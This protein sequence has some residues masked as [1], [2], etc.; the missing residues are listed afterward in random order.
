MKKITITMLILTIISIS[1]IKVDAAKV[2]EK[3]DIKITKISNPDR[4]EREIDGLMEGGDR[5]NSYTWRL[6]ER[7]DYI[8]IATRNIASAL[9]NMYAEAFKEGGIS[10]DVLWAMVD[11]I[12]N[13]DIP[14]NDELNGAN[15]LSYN[16]KTGEFK[17][18][19][20]A[21]A[22]T[23]FRMATTY[24]GNVYFGSYSAD[25]KVS[26][27]I[28]KLDKDGN[29]TKVFESIGAISFRATC[30]YNDHLFFA[31]A[32][33]REV[34]VDS[35][36]TPTKIAI[37]QKS[38]EDDTKW[39][40]VA[41]YKDFGE[42]AYDSIMSSW[43]GAPIWELTTYKGYIYAT[44]PS[45]NGFIIFRGHPAT[46]KETANEYGWYWE[47]V[48]GLHNG[49]N[50][51]GLS[52]KKGGE[53]GTM[54]SLI[55][56]TYVFKDQLYVYNFD[57]SFG[58]E[59]SA[60]AG[61]IQQLGGKDT[62]A[63]EYLKYMYDSLKNPQSMW[64]LNDE[65][66]KFEECKEFTK[67]MEGTT[68]EYVWRVGEHDG[69]MYIATM[70]ASI[71][72]N[73]LTRLTNGSFSNITDEELDQ[74]VTYLNNL[75]KLLI[76]EKG[77]NEKINVDKLETQLNSVKDM[78]SEIVTIEINK[79]TIK[80]FLKKYSN[81]VEYIE[82]E[83]KKIKSKMD[84]E[85]TKKVLEDL[86]EEYKI[87]DLIEENITEENITNLVNLVLNSEQKEEV[88][89]RIKEYMKLGEEVEIKEEDLIKLATAFIKYKT[90]ELLDQAIDKVEE[91][92]NKIDWEGLEMYNYISNM[93]KND[94]WGFDLLRTK[95]GVN[96]EVI[97]NNGF[98]D[99]YNYGASTFLSTKEGL[100]IGTCNPFYGA[101]L[102]LLTTKENTSDTKYEIIEGA[103]QTYNTN[104]TVGLTFRA[105]IEYELFEKF[106]KVFVD[107]I[108]VDKKHYKFKKGSTI[109]EFTQEFT[110]TLKNGNHTL[111]I[112]VDDE[113]KKEATTNFN[114]VKEET[115][116]SN[117]TNQTSSIVNPNTGDP[118]M[119]W[120]YTM[121]L[122]M[123]SL[124]GMTIIYKKKITN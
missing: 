9:V 5:E 75:V 42:Y 84:E 29:F 18:I 67:L 101:Q 106:G 23:Y 73:Y 95:D 38:N 110:N 89:K 10:K 77:L 46:K 117:V 112:L 58:G 61:M 109:I 21:E 60:F 20:T 119:K 13:G 64:K 2:I 28:L 14:R 85:G 12:T 32:D 1:T 16:K 41:D 123:I 70:D 71:F 56:S 72:Y 102:Y 49:I 86:I 55:G 26:Q 81:S 99:K 52:T 27:Y 66:G 11:V 105:N 68:N 87:R 35:E 45:T 53:P 108:E 24:K 74:Q 91:Y 92:V 54:R 100:Y 6:A 63:S 39:D 118:I 25:P 4:G 30:E 62:K 34:V 44:L 113:K 121:I 124:V 15:I 37:L 3:D 8:Y 69:Q 47:E 31:G 36:K 33:E 111:R 116:N 7:G 80:E 97:S 76:E 103:N 51:P 90:N 43:A 82:E 59:A 83:I 19:Y 40:R 88:I 107:N 114:I 96:F 78:L 98:E 79:E 104:S 120:F 94:T 65:T 48:V 22:T 93:V 50:E 57:H 17:V 115:N 122:S